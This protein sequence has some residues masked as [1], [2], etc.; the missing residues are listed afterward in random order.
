MKFEYKR[1]KHDK[2]QT[3]Y[4][5]TVDFSEF[6]QFKENAYKTLSKDVKVA[7]FRPGKAPR[8][9]I[10]AKLGGS[11]ITEALGRLMPAAA[12]EIV[13][14]DEM[15]PVA[16][17]DYNLKKID[18]KEGIQFTFSFTNYPEIK[19]GDFSKIKVVKDAVSVEKADIDDFIKR[20]VKSSLQVEEIKKHTK[21]TY[22]KEENKKENKK[23]SKKDEE[24]SEQ[25]KKY[26]KEKEE[27]ESMEFKL[28]DE[29][30][31]ALK[32]EE[33]DTLEKMRDMVKKR[34]EEV[35]EKQSLEK[36]NSE[37]IQK[38]VELSKF[39]IP[40]Y[41]IVQTAQGEE[42]QFMSR[43]KELSLDAEI[44]FQTQGTSLDSQKEIWRKNAEERVAVDLVLIAIAR[45]NNLMPTEADVDKEIS[46]IEDANTKA[47]YQN[48]SGREYVKTVIARQRAVEWLLGEVKK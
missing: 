27:Y 9:K 22:K 44:Y 43:L 48:N 12:V 13:D 39:E 11:L 33:Q 8:A 24:K 36:Y 16:A 10:E 28:N 35:Q 37:V 7:G 46:S 17:P 15:N 21:I 4:D 40:E 31:K 6:D 3:E 23:E 41:F 29:L 19:L 1:T 14:K 32:Y 18:E 38:A 25:R 20:L 30:I 45:Q 42:D 47:S 5:V 34:M 26:E 2:D